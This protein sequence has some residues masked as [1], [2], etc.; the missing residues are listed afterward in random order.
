[1]YWPTSCSRSP[2]TSARLPTCL[3]SMRTRA[4]VV[5]W[6][7][8][9]AVAERSMRVPIPPEARRATCTSR[10]TMLPLA[11]RWRNCRYSQSEPPHR[12]RAH[13]AAA[14]GVSCRRRPQPATRSWW[15]YRR[16]ATR[17]AG[18]TTALATTWGSRPPAKTRRRPAR[19]TCRRATRADPAGAPPLD[20]PKQSPRIPRVTCTCVFLCDD[21][22]T[23]STCRELP[24]AGFS[25]NS[26][27]GAANLK[28][29]VSVGEPVTGWPGRLA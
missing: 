2:V 19:A 13:A 1:M 26:R 20:A 9:A 17:R 28:P 24:T 25:M 23:R 8:V 3:A 14:A 16:V 29:S 7:A 10:S 6:V 5:G 15:E 11:S 18:R 12:V 27:I 22:S 21:C 4:V